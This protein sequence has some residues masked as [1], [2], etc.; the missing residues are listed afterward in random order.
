MP[1]EDVLLEN[2]V[3]NGEGLYLCFRCAN[4]RKRRPGF[5]GTIIASV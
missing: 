5:S 1:V 4:T 3:S 2:L